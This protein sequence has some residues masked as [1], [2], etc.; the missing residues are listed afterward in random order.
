MEGECGGELTTLTF[1]TF[2]LNK[3]KK[4]RKKDQKRRIDVNTLLICPFVHSFPF[5]EMRKLPNGRAQADFWKTLSLSLP[6]SGGHCHHR[7]PLSARNS[8]L[9]ES[10]VGHP[11]V[12]TIPTTILLSTSTT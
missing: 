8:V 3:N 10:R 6:S 4:R 11:F 9:S 1:D 5:V 2:L 12:A 7:R